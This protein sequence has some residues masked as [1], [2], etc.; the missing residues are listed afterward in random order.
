MASSVSS[1]TTSTSTNIDVQGIVQQLM[2]VERKPEKLLDQTLS[3]IQTKLSAVGKIQ[4]AL[5]ALQ[6]AARALDRTDTW[7]VA[8]AS[9]SDATVAGVT[10]SAGTPVGNYSL[11]ITKLAQNQ[12][13]VSAPLP[14]STT[15]VGG[16]TLRVQ[17][18]SYDAGGAFTAD[19]TRPEASI[20]IAAGATVADIRSA[21]NSAAVGISASLVNDG[22]GVRLMV[23]STDSGAANGFRLLVTDSDGT[24][25]DGAGLSAFAYDPAA[26]AG[27]G[28]NLTQTQAPQTAQFTL[29]GLALTSQKNRVEGALD[30]VTLDLKKEGGPAV[31]LSVVSDGDAIRKSVDAFVTAY[32]NVNK[33]IE[34]QTK[35][36]TT[37]KKAG[38][39]QGDRTVT[40]L[41]QQMRD[42]LTQTLGTGTLT[43]LSDAGIQ[44]QR[45]G[46]LAVNDTKFTSA[47]ADPTR[48]RTLF[49]NNDSDPTKVGIARRFD[50]LLTQVMGVD[51]A[52]TGAKESLTS[53][54][55]NAQKRRDAMENRM[56]AIEARLVRQYTLLDTKLTQAT[57]TMGSL[58]QAL[59]KL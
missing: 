33:L 52:L 53:R 10:A 24:N 21:I 49:S 44:I 48:L 46:S 35:Y 30:G 55:S 14:A 47:A 27:A 23:R 40:S 50:T 59:A 8:K 15:V 13:A 45:D 43:R 20:T 26:A 16:G 29:G 28:K 41:Q 37:S 56:T 2:V 31:D 38:T 32:N 18:G 42:L 11:Q 58:Q 12:T 1:T 17:L 5:A 36:D 57:T 54:Q 4:S 51:G 25:T 6:D 3:T 34:D 22:T 39:L 7:S 19:A 9:S